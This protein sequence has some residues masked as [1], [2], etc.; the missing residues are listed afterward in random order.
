MAHELIS[1]DSR[2]AE[3]LY[4]YLRGGDFNESPT[5][6]P[7]VW[8]IN[9]HDWP[10]DKAATYRLPFQIVHDK[11]KPD[12]DKVKR[13]IYRDKW[14]QYAEKQKTLYETI[15]PLNRVLFHAF[16][17][18]FLAFGFVPSTYIYCGSPRCSCF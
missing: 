8:V 12:R 1:N 13:A 16:T 6:S 14:W 11:V 3:V 7:A 5:L 4:Q 17:G 9:F 18:K 15:R 2:N 10:L